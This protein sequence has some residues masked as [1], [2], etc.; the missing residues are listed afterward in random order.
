MDSIISEAMSN[1]LFDVVTKGHDILAMYVGG[2]RLIGSGQ[3][4]SDYD[5]IVLTKYESIRPREFLM[6]KGTSRIEWYYKDIM[7][8]CYPYENV[9]SNK[10][11]MFC[12]QGVQLKQLS[13]DGLVYV[14]SGCE[15]YVKAILSLKDDISKIACYTLADYFSKQISEMVSTRKLVIEPRPYRFYY[16]YIYHLAYISYILK[17]EDVDFNLIKSLKRV[18]SDSPDISDSAVSGIIDR[19]KMLKEY[20]EANPL[21]IPS[22]ETK[23]CDKMSA[24]LPFWA[25]VTIDE[26][27]SAS[28][29]Q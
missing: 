3:D 26:L 25:P 12:L 20:V 23:L 4:D 7:D 5:L 19:M 21:D 24:A 18:C 2:S 8:M 10:E 15:D 27:A 17:G 29:A 11:Y 22:E 16:K 9:N 1:S 6:Y 28:D 14:Q 13:Y